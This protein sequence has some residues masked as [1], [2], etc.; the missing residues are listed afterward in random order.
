MGGLRIILGDNEDSFILNTVNILQK[1]GYD[2]IN[3]DNSGPGLLRKIRAQHPDIVI[4]DANLKGMSGFE[5]SNVVEGE[6][7]CP[8]ILTFKS[9]PSEYALQLQKKLVYAYIQKPLNI[10]ILNYTIDN[11]F[12]TFKKL[13][14]LERKLQER[15]LV[16]KAKGLLMKKY[17]LSETEAY[18]Y[19]RKKSMDK[20][21]SIGKLSESIIK[22]LEKDRA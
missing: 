6:G 11:A 12:H 8:C 17:S 5:I 21:V 18:E 4:A 20:C 19:I 7:I 14:N 13:S 22:V 9:S 1:L 2:V 10:E 15:K 3:T 16:E